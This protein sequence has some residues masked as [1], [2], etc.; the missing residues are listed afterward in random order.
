MHPMF[1]SIL[2]VRDICC[3]FL[4]CMIKLRCTHMKFS[5]YTRHGFLRLHITSKSWWFRKKTIFPSHSCK[6]LVKGS[7]EILLHIVA[8]TRKWPMFLI[9]TLPWPKHAMWSH[10]T[11]L[12]SWMSNTVLSL[13]WREKELEY[14]WRPL[15][16][17]SHGWQAASQP[18]EDQRS[19]LKL[20]CN[21]G[22][23]LIHTW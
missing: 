16:N 9:L 3:Y 6:V 4:S 23:Y 21:F 5:G 18:P 1:H 2:W 12:F 8:F 14:L 22:Q 17:S 7:V 11:L 15:M 10:L 20:F 13:S 19:R